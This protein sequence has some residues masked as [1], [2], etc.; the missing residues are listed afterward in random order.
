MDRAPFRS[1]QVKRC[2]RQSI[3]AGEQGAHIAETG[4]RPRDRGEQLGDPDT[5]V[6]IGVD[7]GEGF[8][9]ELESLDRTGER[10]PQFLIEVLEGEKIGAGGEGDLIETAGAEEVPS[11][12]WGGHGKGSAAE[13]EAGNRGRGGKP[14]ERRR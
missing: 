12:S 1:I 3:G 8:F 2:E 4:C 14:E 5:P 10:D 6:A 11:V 9:I 7:E 13:R